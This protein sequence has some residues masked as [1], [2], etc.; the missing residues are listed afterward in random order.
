[1]QH[2]PYAVVKNRHISDV[3]NLYY[4]AFDSFRKIKEIHTLEENDALC[5]T[6]SENLKV[7]LTVIPKLA[8]GIMECSDLMSAE[9]LDEFMNVILRSVR[10]TL[11]SNSTVP[12]YIPRHTLTSPN[13]GYPVA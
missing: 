1:M 11:F 6:I 5:K 12:D 7:H 3:Y 2:L 10:P 9:A 4:N 8:M 13:R